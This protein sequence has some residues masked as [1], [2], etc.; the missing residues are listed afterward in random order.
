[1]LTLTMGVDL[2]ITKVREATETQSLPRFL[3]LWMVLNYSTVRLPHLCRD[4]VLFSCGLNRRQTA[5]VDS[6]FTFSSWQQVH[7]AETNKNYSISKST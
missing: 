5:E 7:S 1:M 2:S 6:P 4:R 3:S